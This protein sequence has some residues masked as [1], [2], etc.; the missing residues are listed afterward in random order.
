MD[1]P[2]LPIK[3]ERKSTLAATR[4]SKKLKGLD[5]PVLAEES[6]IIAKRNAW[7]IDFGKANAA[8]KA[9]MKKVADAKKKRWRRWRRSRKKKKPSQKKRRLE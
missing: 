1:L 5:D 3:A 6:R 4:T 8:I 9:Q 2:N 7:L